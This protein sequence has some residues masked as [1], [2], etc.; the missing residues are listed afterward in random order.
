MRINAKTTWGTKVFIVQFLYR[1]DNSCWAIT[2]DEKGEIEEY[3]I[4]DL[5][6][7]DSQYL[8]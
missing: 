3:S 1:N 4:S 6:V 2:V 8:R 5:L 7:I